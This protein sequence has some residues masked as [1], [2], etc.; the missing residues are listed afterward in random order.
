[1]VAMMTSCSTE[2]LAAKGIQHTLH[3][4]SCGEP[5]ASGVTDGGRGGEPPPW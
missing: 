5:V 2:I 4:C 3:I 1:M